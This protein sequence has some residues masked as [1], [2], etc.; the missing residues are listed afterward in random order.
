MRIVQCKY[1]SK[2]KIIH[3]KHIFQL[4]GTTIAYKMDNSGGDV[5]GHF[6]TSTTLSERARQ[7]ANFLGIKVTESFPLDQYPS[8]KCN[9]A[10]R[11]GEKIYHL[12]FDQQYDTTKIKST[13]GESYV[14]TI[15]EAEKKGFRRAFRYR[16]NG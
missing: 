11:D 6:I 1:W 16:G 13:Q 7:F 9:I 4:Y 10:H 15:A 3:E 12:P 5:Q 2:E 8:I 14:S